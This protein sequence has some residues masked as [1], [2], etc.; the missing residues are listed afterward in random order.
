MRLPADPLWLKIIRIHPVILS[1]WFQS[2]THIPNPKN[3]VAQRRP[4]RSLAVGGRRRAHLR[5]SHEPLA[6]S[7]KNACTLRPNMGK[8]QKFP[9]SL[10]FYP[11]I[12][13]PFSVFSFFLCGECFFESN[14]HLRLII[15]RFYIP[16]L[17][18]IKKMLS[19]IKKL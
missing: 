14:A 8:K 16:M 17:Y 4:R 11:I 3:L 6:K 7:I 19:K 10:T 12:I 15:G 1:T 9:K 5:Q 18:E 2:F 13:Y